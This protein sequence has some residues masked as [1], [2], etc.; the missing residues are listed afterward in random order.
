MEFIGGG[1]L[2]KNG[3]F[4]LLSL[5]ILGLTLF[6]IVLY[7]NGIDI[8][9]DELFTPVIMVGILLT[10]YFISKVESSKMK[11]IGLGIIGSVVTILFLVM[12]VG[13]FIMHSNP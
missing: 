4:T 8:V 5:I 1:K 6:F 9:E 2:Q 10:F 13:S 3:V 7:F 11:R 12:A